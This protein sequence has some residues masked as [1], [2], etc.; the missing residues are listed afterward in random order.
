[1]KKD[2]GI[3]TATEIAE[4]LNL[5][6]LTVQKYARAGLIPAFK[7]GASWRFDKKHIRKWL[8][9]KASIKP[10]GNSDLFFTGKGAQ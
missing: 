9:E 3:M 5:N 1:M 2:K 10:S 8:K 6:S 7:I 4:Y